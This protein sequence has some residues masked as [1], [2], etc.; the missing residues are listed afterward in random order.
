MGVGSHG[1]KRTSGWAG[2]RGRKLAMAAVICVGV[3]LTSIL[4]P[5]GASANPLGEV[6]EG[7]KAAVE[8][9]VSN[10]VPPAVTSPAAPPLPSPPVSTPQLPTKAPPVSVP[11][12][13]ETIP[14]PP[15]PPPAL[16]VPLPSAPPSGGSAPKAPENAAAHAPHGLGPDL[17]SSSG[18]KRASPE[19][20]S[21]AAGN[22]P[23]SATAKKLSEPQVDSSRGVNASP[24]TVSPGVALPHWISRVWPAVSLGRIGRALVGRAFYALGLG[25][26]T[27]PRLIVGVL[28][29]ISGFQPA[30]GSPHFGVLA[31]ADSK[32]GEPSGGPSVGPIH[33]NPETVAFVM[34]AGLMALAVLAFGSEFPVF[35][36]YRRW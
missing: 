31:E 8:G 29:A 25:S 22:T 2:G 6:V 32:R 26:L 12:A 28:P 11:P 16:K 27:A 24:P 10:A 21:I 34:L 3:A 18:G 13:P 15:N 14:S 36:R 35:R 17:G 33:S 7:P 1:D 5:I 20:S 9:V 30:I 19:A 4:A 23:G